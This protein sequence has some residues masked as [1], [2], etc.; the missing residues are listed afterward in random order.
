MGM[1]NNGMT[2]IRNNRS[3]QRS[4]K[5]RFREEGRTTLPVGYHNKND[6]SPSYATLKAGMEMNEIRV[7]SIFGILCVG[8][9]LLLTMWFL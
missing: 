7:F 6:K 2:S 3:L 8:L 5:R 4:T 9:G 1:H